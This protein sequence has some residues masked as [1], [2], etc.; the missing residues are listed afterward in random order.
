MDL[1]HLSKLLVEH[2]PV[3]MITTALSKTYGLSFDE[4]ALV[5]GA[6]IELILHDSFDRRQA[7]YIIATILAGAGS[8]NE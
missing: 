5:L 8:Q 3:A 1:E 4:G 6:T 2:P 7:N